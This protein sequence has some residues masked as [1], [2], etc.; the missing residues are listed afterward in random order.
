MNAVLF[1]IIPPMIFHFE[2]GPLTHAQ[3]IESLK[4][5]Q[6]LNRLSSLSFGRKL[7]N[8]KYGTSL[9]IQV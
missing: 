3:T 7:G 2:L 9:N 5:G 6:A 4:I 8:S 1:S